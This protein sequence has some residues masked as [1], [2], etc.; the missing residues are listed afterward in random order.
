MVGMLDTGMNGVE[1]M[2]HY[3][4]NI[5]QEKQTVKDAVE[6]GDATQIPESWPSS[7]HIVAE[8]VVAVINTRLRCLKLI[9]IHT[10]TP[11]AYIGDEV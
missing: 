9:H 2:R 6:E 4:N 3:T 10:H 5:P 11:S 1:R 7:G 8:N